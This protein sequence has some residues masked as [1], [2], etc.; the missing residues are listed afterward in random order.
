MGEIEHGGRAGNLPERQRVSPARGF[1]I[2]RF[3]RHGMNLLGP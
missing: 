2:S 1:Q 3:D